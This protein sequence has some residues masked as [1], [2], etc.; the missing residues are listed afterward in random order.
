MVI[1]DPIVRAKVEDFLGGQDAVET[2]QASLSKEDLLNEKS[3]VRNSPKTHRTETSLRQNGPSVAV[4]P[5]SDKLEIK[6]KYNKHMSIIRSSSSDSNLSDSPA[7]TLTT[8]VMIHREDYSSKSTSPSSSK[9]TSPSSSKPTSPSSSKPT[10]PLSSKPTSPLSSKPT[11]P[12]SS[13]PTSPLS[14]KP[15]SPLSSKSTSP[16]SSKPT[17]PLTSKPTSPTVMRHEESLESSQ[18]SVWQRQDVTGG[19]GSQ[20]SET[21]CSTDQDSQLTDNTVILVNGVEHVSDNSSTEHVNRTR[22]RS[23]VDSLRDQPDSYDADEADCAVVNVDSVHVDFQDESVDGNI[24]Q[25]F[26]G[27]LFPENQDFST[28]SSDSGSMDSLTESEVS[29][30]TELMEHYSDFKSQGEACAGGGTLDLPSAQ[31]LAKRL[32]NLDGFKK[33]DVAR[34]LGKKNDFSQL[35]AEE[36]LQFFDFAGETLDEAL[37]KFLQA[38]CLTG[39]TQERERVLT[40]FS[41]RYHRNNPEWF[42]SADAVNTLVCSLILLNTDLHGQN[43]GK[44]MSLSAFITNLEG[45]NDGGNYPRDYLKILYHSI[46]SNPIEWA[47]DPDIER[48]HNDS[49]ASTSSPGNGTIPHAPTMSSNPF[50]EVQHDPN[51]KVYMKGYIMRKSIKE[52]NGKKTPRGKRGW[53]MYFA[54]L[55]GLILYF[56]KSEIACQHRFESMCDMLSIHHSL[57]TRAT[58]YTK[59][60]FV[61]RLRL[62]DWSEY[63]LQCSDTGELQDWMQAFNLAAATLSAPPL[64]APIGSQRRFCRPLLPSSQTRYSKQEQLS[65]HESQVQALEAELEDHQMHPPDKGS[66]MIL[67]QYWREKLEYLQYE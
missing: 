64:P 60:Q 30:E 46:K 28:A 25:K 61:L 38:F 51:A 24:C 2:I 32:F 20:S 65:R 56:H 31:R 50:V 42:S 10:S 66:R 54:T 55:R 6:T 11:S 7:R 16:L 27:N 58:D 34:H 45:L 67:I 52:A 3:K 22:E 44:K 8:T 35:V 15:T 43:I 48:Q 49:N 23:P 29:L 4:S 33:S 14:S 40:H 59:K 63:L 53:R 19:T 17:S 21:E 12:L 36:Y 47:V 57:S 1:E 37:R 62:A 41:Q 26:N 5:E 39:E 18:D 13:K 9:P